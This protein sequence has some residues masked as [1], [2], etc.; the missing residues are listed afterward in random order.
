MEGLRRTYYGYENSQH[1][2]KKKFKRRKKYTPSDF[3]GDW[4]WLKLELKKNV[5]IQLANDIIKHMENRENGFLNK[6]TV[7]ASVFVDPRYRILLSEDEITV[8]I[9]HLSDLYNRVKI[10]PE[11]QTEL[12]VAHNTNAPFDLR[13]LLKEKKNAHPL[14]KN[15]GRQQE[16]FQRII[17]VPPVDDL[18]MS[19]IDH[20]ATMKTKE[21]IIRVYQLVCAINSAAPTETSVERSF[22]GLSYILQSRRKKLSDMTLECILLIRL[23]KKIFLSPEFIFLVN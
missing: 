10:V 12:D 11:L 5:H 23:N 2:Y 17:Q 3:Y 1:N 22:S 9:K 7:L 6:P 18:T 19:P 8:A 20:W 13:G 21:P 4:L 15:D 16:M 14:F